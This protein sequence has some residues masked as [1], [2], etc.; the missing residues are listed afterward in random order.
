MFSP[1]AQKALDRWQ[2]MK[3]ILILHRIFPSGEWG[4]IDFFNDFD[5]SKQMKKT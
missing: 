4:V 3:S 2:V 1:N 5:K